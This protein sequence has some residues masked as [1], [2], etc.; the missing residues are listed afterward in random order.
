MSSAH[1]DRARQLMTDPITFFDQSITKMHQIP[2]AELETLQRTAMAIRFKEHYAGIEILRNLAD[3]LRIA[4]VTEF[5]DAVP[6]LYPHTIFKSY[7]SS[8]L[9]NGRFDLLNRWLNKLTTHD[10]ASVD[11]AGCD[12]IEAWINRMDLMT[13]L[14]IIV[15]SGT[16]GTISLIPRD[17]VSAEYGMRLWR[18]FLFQRFGTEP[19]EA[20][21][22]PVVD[23]IWPRFATGK[24]G[25]LRLGGYMKTEF[26]GGDESRFH[27]LY[28]ASLDTDLLFLSSKLKAA[29]AR[30]ELDRLKIDPKLLARKQEFEAMQA[31]APQ[32]MAAFLDKCAHELKEKRVLMIGTFVQL[33]DMA[34]AGLAQ[35]MRKVF[36]ADSAIMM[37]GGLK[38]SNL[39]ANWLDQV[40]A[41]LGVERVQQIYGMSE[42]GV[43]NWACDHGHYHVQPWCIP[44]VLDP[45]TNKPL[46]REGVQTGRAAFLDLMNESHWGG[47]I[48]GDE[49][50][51]DWSTPCP[52]GLSSVHIHHDIMRYSD[53]QGVQDDRITC[54]ATQQVV[55]EVID[56]MRGFES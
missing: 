53:K 55:D 42:V 43:A 9:D 51:I 46:P 24:L 5:N 21:L 7:P 41:F 23:I 49:V 14:S 6:L 38:G 13:P 1:D 2:R 39:P 3:R 12:S 8:L 19:T 34:A 54:A 44:F 18:L 28:S 35:G 17:K 45:D 16:T 33:Y 36:A 32:E 10:I 15:S 20:E 25:S 4:A 30:G 52:C 29:A 56:F 50:T 48:S 31:R 27:P 37:G 22:H 11:V 26:T 47:S 40:K